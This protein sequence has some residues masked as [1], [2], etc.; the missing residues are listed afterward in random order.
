M[1][2]SMLA[3]LNLCGTSGGDRGDPLGEV[4]AGAGWAVH[5]PAAG[6]KLEIEP[7]KVSVDAKDYSRW[8]DVSWVPDTPDLSVYARTAGA[9]ACDPVTWEKPVATDSTWTA[10]GLC[11]RGRRFHWLIARVER[12]GD[13]ALLFFYVA[14]PDFLAFEDA[15]VDF[16][17]TAATFSGGARPVAPPAAATLRARIRAAASTVGPSTSPLPGGGVLSTAVIRDLDLLQ[18]LRAAAR[19]PPD[20]LID[21]G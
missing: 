14:N 16:I 15:W 10:G 2:A 11:T 12:H 21:P 19:P 6:A 18:S 13:R 17:R 4:H 7:S 9:T 5:L 1:F 8:F 20:T 3:L